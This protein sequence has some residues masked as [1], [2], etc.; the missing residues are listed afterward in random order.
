MYTNMDSMI[1]INLQI[2]NSYSFTWNLFIQKSCYNF[3]CYGNM[4]TKI[5]FLNGLFFFFFFFFKQILVNHFQTLFWKILSDWTIVCCCHYQF[6]NL[7]IIHQMTI[8][9][10][11][12]L[13]CSGFDNFNLIWSWEGFKQDSEIQIRLLFFF[14]LD[15]ICLFVFYCLTSTHC[16]KR[17]LSIIVLK[18]RHF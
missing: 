7:I 2:G 3:F 18:G 13:Y 1:I 10:S 6:Y 12:S 14:L 9:L 11:V 5:G 16:K 17:C 8:S 4:H 15:G